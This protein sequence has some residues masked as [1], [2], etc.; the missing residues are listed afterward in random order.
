MSD[1]IEV[2]AVNLSIEQIR[3][4]RAIAEALGIENRVKFEHMDY[5]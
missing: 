1:N 4:A 3:V 2:T 5:R